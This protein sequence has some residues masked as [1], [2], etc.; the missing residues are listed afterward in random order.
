MMGCLACVASVSGGMRPR[1]IA[2][3]THDYK[4]NGTTSLFVALDTKTGS[5]RNVR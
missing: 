5:Q 1:Q 4:R 3:H 2:R